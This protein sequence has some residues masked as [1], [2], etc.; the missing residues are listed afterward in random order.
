MRASRRWRAGG[1]R[2]PP[3]AAAATITRTPQTHA[4]VR[5]ALHAEREGHVRE[6]ERVVEARRARERVLEVDEVLLRLGEDRLGRGRGGRRDEGR[7]HGG[8]RERDDELHFYLRAARRSRLRLA[9]ASRWRASRR[10]PR[11]SRRRRFFATTRSYTR[12]PARGW[13]TRSPRRSRR[14][15][16]RTEVGTSLSSFRNAPRKRCARTC[17]SAG[18]SAR[19]RGSG[20]KAT[21]ARPRDWP[22]SR[23]CASTRRTLN[24][25]V[26][27]R[28]TVS[29]SS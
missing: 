12:R 20:R 26:R 28:A 21:R 2:R 29:R 17:C 22:S 8:E 27:S 4:A 19:A 24:R 14:G 1:Q 15:P 11:R 3:H 13:R 6:A 9:A 5:V 25:Q 7:R 23:A 16:S 10:V 18:G